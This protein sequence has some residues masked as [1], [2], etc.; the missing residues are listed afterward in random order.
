MFLTSVWEQYI[1]IDQKQKQNAL[2][3]PD[4]A[5][6]I[7]TSRYQ[8]FVFQKNFSFYVRVDTDPVHIVT[9]TRWQKR[10]LQ[11]SGGQTDQGLSA[12][13]EVMGF[14]FHPWHWSTCQACGFWWHCCFWCLY[15]HKNVPF[16]VYCSTATKCVHA[17]QPR[18]LRQKGW[19]TSVKI[20]KLGRTWSWLL[21]V[22][23]AKF[24]NFFVSQL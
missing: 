14:C 2:P 6:M 21:K 11:G 9:L 3:T 5:S 15:H 12:C 24:L 16:L 10:R 8:E 23:L 17:L 22:Y 18:V 7:I 1:S 19:N 20:G 13:S 4:S